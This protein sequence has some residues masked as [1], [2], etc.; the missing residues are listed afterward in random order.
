[1]LGD[2]FF[3]SKV[4]IKV[5]SELLRFLDSERSETSD[6]YLTSGVY[7]AANYVGSSCN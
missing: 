1:M 2:V 3:N 7:S 6:S 4:D 5:V